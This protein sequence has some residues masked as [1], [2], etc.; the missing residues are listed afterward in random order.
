MSKN[1]IFESSPCLTLDQLNAYIESK[2]SEPERF[3]VEKHLVDC[4]LCSDAL[5][6][7]ALSSDK[8]KVEQTVKSINKDIRNNFSL[9]HEKKRHRKVYH[10]TAAALL[11]AII[12]FLYVLNNRAPSTSVYAK[13]FKPYPNTIPLTRGEASDALVVK[14]AMIEYE[15]GNYKG[16]L[17][18]LQAI[19]DT[20]GNNIM[21]CFYSGIANLCLDNPKQ[22]IFYFQKVIQGQGDF[23]EQSE[24]YL[25]LAYLKN[26]D[27]EKSKTILKKII[28]NSSKYKE[29]SESLLDS[30][31]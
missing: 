7:M 19:L 14:S 1:N 11:I 13:F 4:A 16:T 17:K 26:R 28:A 6:G 18:I 10:A 24:W 20:E 9:R 2:L 21:A 30:L 15:A 12:S 25:G 5:E 8:G 31:N 22:A 29:Q 3:E 27:M 23:I